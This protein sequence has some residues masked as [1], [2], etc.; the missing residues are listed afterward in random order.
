MI[1]G[2]AQ[3]YRSLLIALA[4]LFLSA[5]G[6]AE[7]RL[8]SLVSDGMVLQQDSAVTIW[9][10]AREGQEVQ[11]QASWHKPTN[12]HSAI[13]NPD[14][15]WSAELETPGAGGPYDIQVR[16]T[17]DSLS[18][19]NI[20]IGEVWLC[21]GQSNMAMP[22]LGFKDQP[23]EGSQE[24]LLASRDDRLRLFSARVQLAEKP[25]EDVEG[26]WIPAKLESVAR[27]SAVGYFFGN[28]LRETLDVPVGM[29]LAAR[30]SSAIESW[31][32]SDA[33]L[34]FSPNDLIEEDPEIPHRAHSSLYNGMIAPVSPYKIRGALWYQGEGNRHDPLP[35]A[36][37]LPRMIQ[38]W[39]HAFGDSQLPFYFAQIA[40]NVE[41]YNELTRKQTRAAYLRET[42]FQT[43]K[44]VPHTGMVVTLDLGSPHTVH[45]PQKWEVA[46]RFA[47]FA[48]NR[49]YG[50]AP[51]GATGPV[52]QN[53]TFE[54]SIAILSFTGMTHGF[55]NYE[56]PLEHFA[57]AGPDRIFHPAKA[58]AKRDGTVHVSS[59]L[60]QE[61][62]A[63][64]YAWK[65]WTEAS[66]FDSA[67]LPASSFRTDDWSW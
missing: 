67:G 51:L 40:P 66:L 53:A 9:G 36:R 14:G 35:Y 59:K 11:V 57:L 6:Y 21:S 50:F 64:R 46:N 18:V 22:V 4:S 2:N 7:L 30:S 17:D 24:A 34:E 63:V 19:S 20:L 45:P 31:L 10:W 25:V 38:S 33:I 16:T 61:P 55:Q 32:P 54:D 41:R 52:F 12:S 49:Q 5:G 43:S 23:V 1:A 15:R 27:F 56:V 28:R 3:Y 44:N 26:Q 48:L 13:A 29:I 37:L 58:V 47:Y 42:Q 39:R 8:P 60:V 65:N 62:V